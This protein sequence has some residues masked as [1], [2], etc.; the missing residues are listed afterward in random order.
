VAEPRLPD[1]LSDW[2]CGAVRGARRKPVR[3]EP[4]QRR[5]LLRLAR[6]EERE[7]APGERVRA[8]SWLGRLDEAHDEAVSTL[9]A[10]VSSGAPIDARVQAVRTLSRM[11]DPAVERTLQRL[12]EAAGEHPAITLAAARGLASRN[13]RKP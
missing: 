5:T 7:S 13:T 11:E 10:V 9:L 8:L 6:G 4:E 12:A 2:A 3:L 1:L